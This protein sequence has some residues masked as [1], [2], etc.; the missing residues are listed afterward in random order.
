MVYFTKWIDITTFL[1]YK[2]ERIFEQ[3]NSSKIEV[4]TIF[5]LT[6]SLDERINNK[7]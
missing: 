4:N 1:K 2:S 3:E 7:N 6:M 5:C